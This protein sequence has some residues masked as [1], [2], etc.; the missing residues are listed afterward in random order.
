MLPQ[1]HL[2]VPDVDLIN[3]VYFWSDHAVYAV[4]TVLWSS[5]M[6]L[7]RSRLGPK[8]SRGKAVKILPAPAGHQPQQL[9]VSLLDIFHLPMLPKTNAHLPSSS[10]SF[11][12]QPRDV[13][14]TGRT[15]ASSRPDCDKSNRRFLGKLREYFRPVANRQSGSTLP[16]AHPFDDDQGSSFETQSRASVSI[17]MPR[18]YL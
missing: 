11:L 10:S 8:S 6:S 17:E 5:P 14:Q 7:C 12:A 13:Q 18:T 15:T 9:E 3:F 2:A 1:A 4:G 16:R